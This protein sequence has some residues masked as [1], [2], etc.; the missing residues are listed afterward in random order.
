M[1]GLT[2]ASSLKL[3]MWFRSTGGLRRLR[4]R[5][6]LWLRL[7]LGSGSGSSSSSSLLHWIDMEFESIWII[8]M[9]DYQ[10]GVSSATVAV[11]AASNGAGHTGTSIQ[12]RE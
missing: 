6:W 8:P 12:E 2:H 5:L 10:V 1:Y 4:L 11:A 9:A 3:R 7:A